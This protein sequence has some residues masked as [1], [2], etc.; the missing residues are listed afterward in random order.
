MNDVLD[1]VEDDLLMT[2]R[3]SMN[4]EMLQKDSWEFFKLRDTYKYLSSDNKYSGKSIDE[5]LEQLK[6]DENYW[7]FVKL[8][9]YKNLRKMLSNCGITDP[10]DFID[11][12]GT[13]IFSIKYRYQIF[14]QFCKKYKEHQ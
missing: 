14:E 4:T 2:V 9:R 1:E 13:T 12:F 5:I 7:E 10:D 3:K 11:Q 8:E 6:K